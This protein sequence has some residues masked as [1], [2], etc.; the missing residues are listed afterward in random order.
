MTKSKAMMFS[1][2]VLASTVFSG[3]AFAAERNL[4]FYNTHTGE[5]QTVTYWRDGR[6]D[7]TGVREI[8]TLL[9]DHRTGDVKQIDPELLDVLYG[10]QTELQN[11]KPSLTVEFHIISG[12]R[13][14]RTNEML[15][16]NV[17]G[18]AKKSRHMHGDAIDIRVPGVSTKE[19]RNIAWCQQKGGVGYYENSHFVHVDIYKKRTPDSRFSGGSRYRAWGWT[20]VPGLCGGQKSS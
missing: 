6:Y 18:Q 2:A 14:P 13:S 8:N 20:P 10:I 17:G 19:L 11:K 1:L 15:R 3:D 7:R 4:A 9:R 5:R 16:Q 12:F